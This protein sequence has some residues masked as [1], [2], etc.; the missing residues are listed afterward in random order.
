[1][2]MI[3]CPECHN[4]VSDKAIACPHCGFGVKDYF[5]EKKRHDYE[6]MQ[7]ESEKLNESINLVKPQKP[8]RP[9][10]PMVSATIF[11]L[12]TGILL[13]LQGYFI[14]RLILILTLNS[15]W[16]IKFLTPYMKK[17]DE[18]KISMNLYEKSKIEY[19]NKIYIE[20]QKSF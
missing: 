6:S 13:Q 17:W 4:D 5:D 19:E 20:D 10:V 11:G 3:K 8:K 2:A 9:K 16:I 15:L 14:I 18:Y 1:M 7:H 12:I